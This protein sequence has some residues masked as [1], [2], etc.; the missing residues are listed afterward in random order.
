MGMTVAQ[1]FW[2]QIQ[3]N[4]HRLMR[5]VHR[6]RAPRWF[7]I[8][9]IVATRGGD[10]WLWYA[11]GLILVI[12]GGAH[13]FAAIGAATSAAVAGIFIFRSLKHASHRKRPCEIEP[14]CWASI[15]PPDKYSFPSGHSITAFAVAI[16]IGL[17]YP[18]LL[19]TLQDH[20]GHAL[21]ERRPRRRSDWRHSRRNRLP[22]VHAPLAAATTAG[23]LWATT[24][25]VLERNFSDPNHQLASCITN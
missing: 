10:G 7:R 4:D 5:K 2:N 12:F 24:A 13:R 21:P 18:E 22:H 14:H 8:L 1:S 23:S 20:S 9:M 15:L 16:A 25:S 19:G 11:L 3:S 6:W 17:F